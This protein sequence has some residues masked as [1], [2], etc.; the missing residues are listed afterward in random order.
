MEK[1]LVILVGNPR[2]GE[3][4]WNSMYRNLLQP[5]NADLA[6]C[7]GYRKDKSAS[8]YSVAKYV[9]EIP[10]YEEWAQYYSENF[11]DDV[12]VHGQIIQPYWKKSFVLGHNTGFSG[13][14]QSR[15]S[16]AITLAFRH[17][18]LKNKKEIICSYD[19]IIV[20]RSDLFYIKEHPILPN[21]YFWVPFGESYGGLSDR[22]HIFPSSD[23]DKVFGIVENYVNNEKLYN[24]YKDFPE[25]LN[26][27]SCYLKY[28]NHIGY[29][30][31]IKE[32]L[33]VNFTVKTSEDDTRWYAG[34]HTPVPYHD[35]LFFKYKTD[36]DLC[37][38]S[39][40]K[41]ESIILNE[42]QDNFK[43]NE[44]IIRT[45]LSNKFKITEFTICL[46]C[47][48]NI[49]IVNKQMELLKPLEEKYKVHWNNRI[50]RHPGIYESYSKLI[51][52]SVASSPTEWVILINDRTIPTVE[53]VEK[54]IN[55]LE[56]G[57]ACVLL[58]NVGFMGFSKELIRKIGWWDERFTHAGW[59]DRDWVW[60][61]SMNNL[62]LYE[63]Q[64]ST[65]DRSWK[66]SL[67]N[68]SYDSTAH[69]YS[70][71]DQTQDGVIYKNIPEENYQ[72]WN[73]CIGD[74]ISKISDSWKSWEDSELNVMYNYDINNP[75]ERSGSS[76]IKG[77]KIIE[78]F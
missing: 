31:K 17:Y 49:E 74:S 2:G 58:Y 50:D 59:E 7:F 18:L 71:Y 43:K 55:L 64:E 25:S 35:N 68:S 51:N 30:E 73:E 33:P 10:E 16:S 27:E 44:K 6:L 1:T 52:H 69:W 21:N 5:Y 65:Y 23:V 53:E 75:L 78:N 3:K 15:G 38:K 60:R 40:L 70:K 67:T 26:I 34:E 61:I 45:N 63:S 62:A 37:I 8:L 22:H 41:P 20:T 54:M 76:M 28:F 13:I 24:D 47:G 11:G 32:Y 66:T 42:Y 4:T 19:R 72:H 29:S 12:Y 46:H 48:C 9:W 56:N 36:Y 77:R 14:Y 39:L 57:F